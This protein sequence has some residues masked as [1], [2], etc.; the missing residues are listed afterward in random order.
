MQTTQ[1]TFDGEY[2]HIINGTTDWVYE[3]EFAIT[4]GFFWN[5]A[6]NKIAYYRFDESEVK[7]PTGFSLS[8]ALQI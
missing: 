1:V 2:N 8:N 4:Q 3:E 5:N 7:V 6:G